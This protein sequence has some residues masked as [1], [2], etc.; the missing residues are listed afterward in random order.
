MENETRIISLFGLIYNLI[1]AP[2]SQFLSFPQESGIARKGTKGFTETEAE[3]LSI[4]WDL[5]QA[6]VEDVRK[7]LAGSPAA[8]TVRTLL[9]VTVDRG[10]VADNGKDYARLYHAE[11][12][13]KAGQQSALKRVIDTV[14]GGSADA[15]L[16]RLMDDEEVD[17]NRLKGLRKKLDEMVQ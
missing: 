4:I 2:N 5:G 8:S 13:K 14:F 7:R 17:I 6:S 9:M 16:L 1:S 11:I 10:F 3:I 15:M 12:D